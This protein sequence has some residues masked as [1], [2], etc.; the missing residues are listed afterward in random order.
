[1]VWCS[2]ILKPPG[3]CIILLSTVISNSIVSHFTLKGV[4]FLHLVVE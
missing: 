1:M 2:S 4:V 3:S